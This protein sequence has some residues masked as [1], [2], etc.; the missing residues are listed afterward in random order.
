L[1]LLF[2][3][4]LAQTKVDRI[5]VD[6]YETGTNNVLIVLSTN[7][8]SSQPPVTQVSIYTS[9]NGATDK[10]ILGGE[11]DL[12]YI[13]TSGAASR[14]FSSSVS[15]VDGSGQWEVSTPNGATGSVLMQYDSL[16]NS[17]NLDV[18][19]F[20]K[21]TGTSAGIDL[22]EGGLGESFHTTIEADVAT[23]YSINVYSPNGNKCTTTKSVPAGNKLQDNIIPFS[24]F[25]GSCDF[26]N[27]GA[28][29]ISIQALAN[30]D[31]VVTLFATQG[32]PDPATPSLTS[33]PSIS[34]SP[35]KGAS[36]SP[37]PSSLPAK[38]C[39]CQCPAFTCEL[40][41]DVDDDNNH[42]LFFVDD[43]GFANSKGYFGGY[44]Y[45]YANGVGQ[46]GS[47]STLVAS[48]AAILATFI[49]FF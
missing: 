45:Y 9:P 46:S 24:S 35:S 36:P 28:I 11:R 23:S 25:T 6:D 14:V 48:F 44:G 13:V 37:S 1:A 29:E 4:V 16:D 31:S 38:E 22:T 12:E 30:V 21:I 49:G 20:T 32:S 5:K 34:N 17:I 47:A 43:D 8:T 7:L 42:A 26:K 18:K 33:S 39:F 15:I 3:T 10:S 27:V 19:G 41:F 40:I 2:A